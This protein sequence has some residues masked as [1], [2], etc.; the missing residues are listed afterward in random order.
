MKRTLAALTVIAASLTACTTDAQEVGPEAAPAS[1]A[2]PVYRPA[3]C[4]AR[5]DRIYV[6]GVPRDISDGAECARLSPAGYA[7]L[8]VQVLDNHQDES[9]TKLSNTVPWDVAW[10]G[11]DVE[12]QGATCELLRTEGIY[13]VGDQLGGGRADEDDVEMALYFLTDRCEV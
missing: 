5:L 12:M 1:S 2:A 4:L 13:E 10:D 11:I 8:V 6:S 3:D 7:G 9:I